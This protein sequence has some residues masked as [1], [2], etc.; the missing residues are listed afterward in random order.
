VPSVSFEEVEGER[1]R[2]REWMIRNRA[3]LEQL[4]GLHHTGSEVGSPGR[5][6]QRAHAQHIPGTSLALELLLARDH[7][8]AA[9]H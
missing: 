7:F 8:D 4:H 9:L 5:V 2:E 6:G 1:G 3:N